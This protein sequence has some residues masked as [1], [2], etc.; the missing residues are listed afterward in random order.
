M[1]DQAAAALDRMSRRDRFTS[2]NDL[3][4]CNAYG[5][6]LDGS[7]LRRRYRRAQAAAGVRP[8]RFHDLRHT[9]GSLLAANGVDVVAIQK[10]MGHSAL[11]TTSR[12]LHARP[13]SEQ[14]QIFTAAFTTDR[15][16]PVPA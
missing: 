15:T 9:F 11:A 12:Y 2:S 6:P 5:R 13:A 1:A 8:L 7:A 16:A 4:F 3:V 14:A 10:A